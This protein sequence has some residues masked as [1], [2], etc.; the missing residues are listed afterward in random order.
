MIL[1]CLRCYFCHLK[2][3]FWLH[4]NK[5]LFTTVYSAKGQIFA[6]KTKHESRG[7][8]GTG[9]SWIKIHQSIGKSKRESDHSQS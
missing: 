6:K 1:F 5:T 7:A 8:I 4:E 9:R 2:L 3:V